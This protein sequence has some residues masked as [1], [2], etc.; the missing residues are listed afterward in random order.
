MRV[1][2]TARALTC[3]RIHR[4]ALITLGLAACRSSEEVHPD[5]AALRLA[6]TLDT[7][8]NAS[9]GLKPFQGTGFVL[10]I[11]REAIVERQTD[12]AGNPRW[13]VRAP[14]QLITAGI[15]TTDTTRYTDDRPL[16]ALNISLGRKPAAQSLKAWGDSVVASHEAT[17]DE[18]TKGEFGALYTVAGTTAYLRQPTC[19]D[20]GVYIFTFANR[21]R[22]V[23]IQYS[24]DT[25]EPLAVRKDGIYALILATFR[26]TNSP[27]A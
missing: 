15:G 12:S 2:S 3:S 16:Y 8:T 26:W 4:L 19:G 21:D 5:S 7:A 24:T 20:C 9:Y 25:V 14:A 17:A 13:L 18:L 22:L 1:L 27:P 6:A 11:P 10:A 23:E